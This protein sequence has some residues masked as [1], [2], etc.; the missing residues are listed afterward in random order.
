MQKNITSVSWIN[1][2]DRQVRYGE[3]LKI[4]KSADTFSWRKGRNL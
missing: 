3:E 4:L 2:G 1:G